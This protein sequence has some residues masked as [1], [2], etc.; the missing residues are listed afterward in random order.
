M[1]DSHL[2]QEEREIEEIDPA[3]QMPKLVKKMVSVDAQGPRDRCDLCRKRRG[4]KPYAEVDAEVKRRTAG[5]GGD[6]RQPIEE[7]IAQLEDT[8]AEADTLRGRV[9]ELEAEV[10]MLRNEPA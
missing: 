3:T 8:E 1:N 2:H 7:L 10:L 4:L 6:S 5:K 9:R